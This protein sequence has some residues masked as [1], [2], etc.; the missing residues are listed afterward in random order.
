VFQRVG[1]GAVGVAIVV[2]IAIAVPLLVNPPPPA[3][4]IDEALVLATAESK[5]YVSPQAAEDLKL[6]VA[7]TQTDLDALRAINPDWKADVDA[8]IAA[9]NASDLDEAHAAFA[10]I[11]ALISTRRMDLAREEARLNNAQA[12][13]FYPFE[14]SKSAPLLCEAARLAET[15][16]WYWIDCGR[17]L[18]ATGDL[19]KARSAA[20]TALGLAREA[21]AERDVS[22]VLND[23]GDVLVAEGDLPAARAAYDEG[24]GIARALLSRDPGNAGWQRDM[25]VSHAKLAGVDPAAAASHWAEAHRIANSMAEAGTLAPADA[26]IPAYL[27]EK[28][29]AAVATGP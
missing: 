4:V 28:L 8:A 6:R 13:L 7:R 16:I 9:F 23:L 19:P 21:G 2:A 18:Q 17:A 29:D 11:D 15:E 22:V 25:I 3:V 1:L 24:L 27:R 20:E 10:R 26:W 12:T 14:A 5:G